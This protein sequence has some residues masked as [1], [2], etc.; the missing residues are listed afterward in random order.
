MFVRKGTDHVDGAERLKPI[1]FAVVRSQPND[2]RTHTHTHT[3]SNPGLQKL[4]GDTAAS[5][6]AKTFTVSLQSFLLCIVFSIYLRP[7]SNLHACV[8]V[9]PPHTA[10]TDESSFIKNYSPP[11]PHF[12]PVLVKKIGREKEVWVGFFFFWGGGGV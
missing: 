8:F 5:L 9:A 7:L 4:P 10:K 12:T 6:A 2:V 1:W 11:P 3:Q